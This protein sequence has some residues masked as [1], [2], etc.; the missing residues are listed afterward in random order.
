MLLIA[1]QRTYAVTGVAGLGCDQL[2]SVDAPEFTQLMCPIIRVVYILLYASGAVFSMMVII[3]AYKYITAQGDPK[4][5]MG[6]NLSGTQAV[7]G[8]LMIIGSFVVLRLIMN[9]TGLQASMNFFDDVIAG[10][11]G[12]FTDTNG[13][14]IIRGLPGCQ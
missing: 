8:F 11:C 7:I 6:A 5:I 1:P 12:I 9:V 2:T 14:L 4:G 10:I 13:N 3:T